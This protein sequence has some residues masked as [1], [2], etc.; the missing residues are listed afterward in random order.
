MGKSQVNP[1]SWQDRL[2]F[3]Q[4]WRVDG[5]ASIVFVA[6]QMALALPQLMI[7]IEATAVPF[8]GDGDA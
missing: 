1:W 7:E 8:T 5:A 2:G 6:G 4:A 3:S